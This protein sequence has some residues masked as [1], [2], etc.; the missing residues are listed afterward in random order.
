VTVLKQNVRRLPTNTFHSVPIPPVS[1][2]PN[3]PYSILLCLHCSAAHC[4]NV[5]RNGL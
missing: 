5:Y 1:P 4:T 3:A 2:C